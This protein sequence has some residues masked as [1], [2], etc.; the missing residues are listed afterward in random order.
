[1]A[2]VFLEPERNHVVKLMLARCLTDAVR[3]PSDHI[4]HRYSEVSDF[5]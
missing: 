5:D 2:Q 1:M 4:A 3:F